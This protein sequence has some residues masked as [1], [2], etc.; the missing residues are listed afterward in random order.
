MKQVSS[1][2]DL[3]NNP[4]LYALYGGND[5][6]GYVAYVGATDKLRHRINQH[7][8]RQNSSVTTGKSAVR[9]ETDYI[10]KICWWE[11]ESFRDRNKL[12]AAE[13]VAF[14]VLNPRLTSGGSPKKEAE[15]FIEDQ[16]FLKLIQELLNGQP[17]GVIFLR[18]LEER[19][20]NLEK[21]LSKLE[22]LLTR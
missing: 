22:E 17:T 13:L 1:I 3:P 8:I 21:R 16:N 9:L 4:S 14:K 7:L 6:R 2:S 19:V 5:K 12:E 15:K 11:H 10:F 20:D 18:S